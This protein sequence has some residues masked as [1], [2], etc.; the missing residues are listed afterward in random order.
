M[1]PLFLVPWFRVWSSRWFSKLQL[2]S[3]QLMMAIRTI[4]A[5]ESD[6]NELG[7]LKMKLSEQSELRV[8]Y[9][10]VQ[11]VKDILDLYP[12]KFVVWYYFLFGVDDIISG[13]S[14]AFPEKIFTHGLTARNKFING[15][16]WPEFVAQ[17]QKCVEVDRWWKEHFV[18]NWELLFD[19][20]WR[21]K[22]QRWII[23]L[24]I[25]NAF[26]LWNEK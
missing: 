17:S 22:T 4:V 5:D 19:T 3:N 10:I 21:T 25:I 12:G 18:S 23:K 6:F 20:N 1:A 16:G 11:L 14:I 7:I 13:W 9:Y 26:E 2:I 8:A 24:K 15:N